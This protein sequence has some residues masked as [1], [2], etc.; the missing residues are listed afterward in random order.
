[1]ELKK[2]SKKLTDLFL[3]YRV[4]ILVLIIGLALML[5]PSGSKPT[6]SGTE[7]AYKDNTEEIP[8]EERLSA[9]LSKI[10]GAG[11]VTVLL[12]KG[13]GEQTVYQTD[14]D[15]STRENDSSE[16]RSTVTVTDAQRNQTGLIQQ[17][18]PP[19]YMGAIVL[20][21]GANDPTVR[22]SVTDAVSKATGLGSDRISV[23]KMK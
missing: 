2:L 9:I 3:K 18:N 16:R 23:L 6:T 17:V 19:K 22:L 8:L 14:T 13:E 12:S 15:V 21:E 10:H 11:Q 5:I 4:V 1:M 20:C 7:Q